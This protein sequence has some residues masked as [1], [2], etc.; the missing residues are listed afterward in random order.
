MDYLNASN[1]YEIAR[2]SYF[3]GLPTSCD[4]DCQGRPNFQQCVN[5]CQITRHTILGQADL[6]M[7][8]LALDTCTPST[9]DE[10]AAARG[11]ADWCL[12]QYNPN[13]YSDPE[14]RMAVASQYM[15]CREASKVDSCQ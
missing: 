15:A 7:T 9:I 6:A 4:Q 3:Y 5:D 8:S 2:L 11:M 10:C 1:A 14:E 12:T 13:N